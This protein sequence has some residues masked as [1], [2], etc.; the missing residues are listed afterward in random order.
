MATVWPTSAE[1]RV[2]ARWTVPIAISA[3][4]AGGMLAIHPW[5][6]TGV[7]IGAA[8]MALLLIRPLL[9][10]A[11]LL[12]LG[13]IDLSFLTGGLKGLF[14]S[15][16]GFDM[17][18]IRLIGVVAGFS[19]LFVLERD[20]AR[21]AFA[22]YSRWYLV[23]LLFA[24]ATLSYS[25]DLLNGL[26][27][28]LKLAYPLIVFLAVLTFARTS[29][30]VSWLGDVVL[31]AAAVIALLINPIYVMAGGYIVDS[32]GYI[33]VLGVGAHQNP[34]SFYLISMILLA[35]SRYAV[36]GQGRYLALCGVLAIWV[37]LTISRSAL[38]GVVF[39]F[40]A[41][42]IYNAIVTRNYR[43]VAISGVVGLA[44]A[45]PLLPFVLQR[46]FGYIPSPGELFNL[47]REPW[48]LYDAISWQGR[49]II[50]PIVFQAFQQSPFIGLGIGSQ[51][52]VVAAAIPPEWG[53]IVH[54]EYLRLLT[55]VGLAGGALY[56]FA[57]GMWFLAV[58]RA[59]RSPSPLVREY[60]PAAIGVLVVWT[61]VAITENAFDYYSPFTQFA[62]F[63]CGA[64]V[65]AARA[66]E[67]EAGEAAATADA[68]GAAA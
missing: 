35:Y 24:L 27:F 21:H 57:V 68:E 67:A 53:A 5:L 16:G 51:T 19:V 9:V 65:A 62:G 22:W 13:P 4:A 42:A 20:M 6:A 32:S 66:H 55:D 40:A 52:A 54:N 56:A 8:L 3:I 34:F 17:N 46:T 47:A 37:T 43:A 30:Q 58:G 64:A 59:G 7:V 28:L 60:A 48:A 25:M 44:V 18:G 50:W 63:L 49:E 23:F 31:V 29:R 1:R 15:Y 41:A 10:L 2:D 11:V 45:L 38:V 12:A 26:K 14:L 36:R 33:R 61:M 39:G